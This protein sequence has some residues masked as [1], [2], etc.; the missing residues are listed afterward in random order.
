MFDL[1]WRDDPQVKV[2]QWEPAQQL[3]EM[4]LNLRVDCS[5]LP[6][7]PTAAKTYEHVLKR[8]V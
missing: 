3:S 6:N 7:A 8:F 4:V 1:K 2:T 5:E